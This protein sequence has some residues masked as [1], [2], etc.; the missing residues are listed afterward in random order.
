[1]SRES[2]QADSSE[3]PKLSYE[4]MLND[5]PYV[6]RSDFITSSCLHSKLF[7]I[8]TNS[9]RIHVF[10]HQGNKVEQQELSVHLKAVKCISIDNKGEYFVSCSDDRLVVYGLCNSEHNFVVMPDKPINCIAIDP[11]FYK[12]GNGRRFVVGV[13]KLMLYE[14][15]FLKRYKTVPIQSKDDPI[16]NV[17]WFGQFIAWS[18]KTEVRIFDIDQRAIITKIKQDLRDSVVERGLEICKFCWK[19][20]RT[21]LIGWGNSVK[22]C[23]IK[24]RTQELFYEPQL[25]ELPRKYVEITS[26][27]ETELKILGLA[28]FGENLFTLSINQPDLEDISSEDTNQKPIRPQIHILETL[29]DSYNELSRDILTPNG[30]LL[31]N[32]KWIQ[33]Y[34]LSSIHTDGLYFIV[35]PKDVILA[36]PRDNDDHIDW[37]IDHSM[38]KEAYLYAKNNSRKLL[39]H[40]SKEIEDMYIKELKDKIEHLMFTNSEETAK[41][42]VENIDAIPKNDVVERLKKSPEYLL[43]YLH[44]LAQK[45]PDSCLEYHDMMLKLYARHKKDSLLGF[46]KMSTNYKLEEALKI[47]QEA[48]LIKEVVYLYGRMGNLKVALKYITESQGDI[49]E[50]IEFCKEHQD[51][52]LWQDL[53]MYSMHRP[54]FISALLKN[55]GTHISDPIELIDRIPSGFEIDGLMPA[56]VKILQDYQLQIS[57]EQ[58][59]RDL[60]ASDCFGLLQKQMSCQTRGIIIKK[61]QICDHCNQPLFNSTITKT[62]ISADEA[63]NMVVFGCHHVFHEDCSGNSPDAEV[64][65]L[66]NCRICMKD[67]NMAE[68]IGAHKF[69]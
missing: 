30:N 32:S 15:G 38:L 33:N 65:K 8:G 60:M 54:E 47:C 31:P 4:R 36:K 19:D 63:T 34:S 67:T 64:P 22:I 52:E 7:A 42:L 58:S 68:L 9:G 2:L 37:L 1:M 25:K 35:C 12:S 14:R 26:M 69:Q 18:T 24:D 17:S 27:F 51:S 48:N 13:D 61:E 46:L 41:L 39:R 49:Y 3:E 44:R 6:V 59:C 66:L 40:S 53:I 16:N 43:A 56:L 57:L 29:P 50:A 62:Q 5:L 55:I 23:M 28:P 45:D 20:N 21:L 11:Y 10:D